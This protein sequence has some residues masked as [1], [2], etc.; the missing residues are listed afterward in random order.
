MKPGSARLILLIGGFFFLLDR[1]LKYLALASSEHL[2]NTYFGW[3]PFLNPGIAFGLPLP[4]WLTVLFT[5]PVLGFMLYLLKKN[6]SARQNQ[7]L[8]LIWL[9]A[10]SNLIDRIFYKN[11]VDYFLVIISIFNIADVLIVAGF[12]LYFWSWQRKLI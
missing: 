2:V 1:L 9:G 4:T 5:V 11:T 12:L 3:K 8:F 7:A 6:F 10:L